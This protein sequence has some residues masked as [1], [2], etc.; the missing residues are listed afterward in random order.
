[1]MLGFR[2][3]LML[4]AARVQT[5]VSYVTVQNTVASQS[6]YTF[7]C[8]IA[9]AGLLIVGVAAMTSAGIDR[10]VTS[11]T[12]GGVESLVANTATPIADQSTAI[13]AREMAA[14]THSV[15][16]TFSGNQQACMLAHWLATAY[17]NPVAY[18]S[19]KKSEYSAAKTLNVDVPERGFAICMHVHWT[20]AGTTWTGATERFDASSSNR[21]YSGADYTSTG[22]LEVGRTFTASHGN[23]NGSLSVATWE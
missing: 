21:H 3:Q 17:N 1:M 4:G 10:N 7:N 15:V 11:I 6:S 20:N 22:A 12:I 13:G 23:E 19:D 9:S 2:S 16:V 14:G 18:D 8:T 5:A